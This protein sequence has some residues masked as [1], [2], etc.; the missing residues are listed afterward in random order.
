MKGP[1]LL[2]KATAWLACSM[3]LALPGCGPGGAG[4]IKV[5]PSYKSQVML[6]PSRKTPGPSLT[7]AHRG[8]PVYQARSWRR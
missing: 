2:A 5:D 4:S 8:R 6:V 7:Q 3:A 1:R